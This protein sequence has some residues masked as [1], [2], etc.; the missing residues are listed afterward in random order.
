MFKP[1]PSPKSVSDDKYSRC[2]SCG[3]EQNIIDAA[4]YVRGQWPAQLFTY[5]L[6]LVSLTSNIFSFFCGM[7]RSES[8]STH[9]ER[10]IQIEITLL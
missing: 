1:S 6:Q 8:F 10:N 5:Q 9:G 7:E 4:I 3:S 2:V